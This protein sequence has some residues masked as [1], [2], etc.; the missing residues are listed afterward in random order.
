MLA[1]GLCEDRSRESDFLEFAKTP[2]LFLI[3][4]LYFEKLEKKNS[5]CSLSEFEKVLFEYDKFKLICLQRKQFLAVAIYFSEYLT[6]EITKKKENFEFPFE[7]F[8]V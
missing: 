1:G 4:V 3:L 8:L 7:F 2:A 6:R 5:Y